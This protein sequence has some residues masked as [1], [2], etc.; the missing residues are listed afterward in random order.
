MS[1]IVFREKEGN[2]RKD[3]RGVERRYVKKKK[4]PEEVE[5]D[6]GTRRPEEGKETIEKNLRRMGVGMRVMA[7]GMGLKGDDGKEGR[8]G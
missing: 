4:K 5:R 7:S 1:M 6:E 8:Y 2:G 3:G